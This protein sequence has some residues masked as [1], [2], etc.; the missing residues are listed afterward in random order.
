MTIARLFFI[1]YTFFVIGF[2]ESLAKHNIAVSKLRQCTIGSL[3]G[4]HCSSTLQ[5]NEWS[6]VDRQPLKS[7]LL[8]LMR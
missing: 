2:C 7:F 6:W 4:Q 1:G 5:L 3:D 8:A